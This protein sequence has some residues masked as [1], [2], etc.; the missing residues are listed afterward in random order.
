[1]R[2]IYSLFRGY[3]L[4][5]IIVYNILHPPTGSWRMQRIVRLKLSE[6]NRTWVTVPTR[7][8]KPPL[9]EIFSLEESCGRRFQNFLW[10]APEIPIHIFV[11]PLKY[12]G[13]PMVGVRTGAGYA[14]GR[15]GELGNWHVLKGVPQHPKNHWFY[16]NDNKTIKLITKLSVKYILLANI[17]D[18]IRILEGLRY[19]WY[20]G[21]ARY[22]ATHVFWREYR[23]TRR[24]VGFIE[25]IT[26]LLNW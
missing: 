15:L 21:Q 18:W 7:F 11:Y 14:D 23:S 17:F 22:E 24:A 25:L 3:L 26:K 1:M 13:N 19:C 10:F 12:P 9:N 16:W 5:S 2:L 6:F 8:F 20:G 4:H